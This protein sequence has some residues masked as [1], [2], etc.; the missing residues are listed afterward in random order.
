MPFTPFHLG[1]G[2]LAGLLFKRLVNL[3]AVLLAGLIIDVKAAYCFIFASCALHGFFHTFLGALLLSVPVVVLVY[4][5]RKPLSEISNFL[6]ISQSYSLQSIVLGAVSGAFM[7]IILDSFLYDEM[8]PFFPAAGNPLFG[9]LDTS[10]VYSLCAVLLA[11]GL[12]I[13]IYNIFSNILK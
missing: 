5:L 3:P 7:H 9:I 13:Y 12:L 11:A 1:P 8:S 6:K 10:T 4:L 2:L